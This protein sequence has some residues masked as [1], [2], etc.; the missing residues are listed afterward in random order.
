MPRLSKKAQRELQAVEESRRDEVVRVADALTEAHKG[1][2]AGKALTRMLAE[3][4]RSWDRAD[5]AER[6]LDGATMQ[7]GSMRQRLVMA[8]RQTRE[9][10]AQLEVLRAQTSPERVTA[11]EAEVR[12]LRAQLAEAQAETRRA[13][14]ARTNAAPTQSTT[15]RVQPM[16]PDAAWLLLRQ[17]PAL[18]STVAMMRPELLQR[19]DSGEVRRLC[20]LLTVAAE[21]AARAAA[22]EDLRAALV[23]LRSRAAT[24][25]LGKALGGGPQSSVS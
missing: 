25:S 4:R 1:K 21:G 20:T 2:E 3:L 10:Q 16:L 5:A 23:I 9:A 13:Q 11:L 14:Y 12:T 18:R 17:Q 19:E 8:Q 7:W 24:A 22:L 15:S 6:R